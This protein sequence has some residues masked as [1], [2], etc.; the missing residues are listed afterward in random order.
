[1]ALPQYVYDGGNSANQQTVFTKK[2]KVLAVKLNTTTK[3][4]K[5]HFV[6]GQN[7]FGSFGAWQISKRPLEV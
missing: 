5:T 6:T 2:L 3:I 7:E 4:L 1:M